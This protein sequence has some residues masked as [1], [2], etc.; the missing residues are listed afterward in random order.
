MCLYSMSSQVGCLDCRS[1][2]CETEDLCPHVHRVV[3]IFPIILSNDTSGDMAWTRNPMGVSRLD[4]LARNKTVYAQSMLHR[5][6]V[7]LLESLLSIVLGVVLCWA[8]AC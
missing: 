4:G 5:F 2:L 3:N 1:L 6:E 7:F 8:S